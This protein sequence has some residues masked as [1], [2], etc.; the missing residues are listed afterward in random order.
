MSA[1]PNDLTSLGM[2]PALATRLGMRFA[3]LDGS[4]TTQGAGAV[5]YGGTYVGFFPAAGDTAATLD[6]AFP[7][8]ESCVVFNSG[9]VTGRL[10]PP[11]G[12]RLNSVTTNTG[13]NIPPQ[14]A[15]RVTMLTATVFAAEIMSNPI[16]D[17][18]DGVTAH[19]G[20]GQAS[21]TQLTG[22]MANVSTVATAADSVK[23]PEANA[24][25]FYMLRNSAANSMQ[26]F[27]YGTDTINAVATGTGVAQAATTSALYF[28]TS[29]APAG[30]WFR[31]LSA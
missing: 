25:A 4:G 27:G 12:G 22:T 8:G 16:F 26:V 21:A 17:A 28:C 3:E 23:L 18:T 31:V 2:P 6:S 14:T 15:V 1:F 29:S 5:V 11:S 30:K 19:A 13:I 24:G 7:V 20:G 9:T 10:F